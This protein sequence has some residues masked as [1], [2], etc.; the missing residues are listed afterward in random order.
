MKDVFD[1]VITRLREI[2]SVMDIKDTEIDL[3]VSPKRIEKKNLLVDG[4]KIESWRVL[5]ND[6]LGPGKGGIRFHPKVSEAEVKS[7]AFWMTLKNSLL[8]L[9]F[10]GAKG[11]IKFNP[12]TRTKRELENISRIYIREHYLN[13][14]QDKDIPAPDVYTNPQIMG[15]MLDEYEKLV[16]HH[17]PGMITGKPIEIGGCQL[18]G[19]ATA[20]GGFI[21]FNEVIQHDGLGKKP[22]IAIQGFGNAGMNIAKMLY[23]AGFKIIAVSDSKGGLLDGS[24]LDINKVIEIKSEKSSVTDGNGKI[25]TNNELLELKVDI[26][27]LAALEDQ[28]TVKN[29]DKIQAKYIIELANGPVNP[30]ADKILVSKK[31]TVVPDILANA[32]GVVVSYFEWS[33]NRTGGILEEEYLARKL[34]TMMENAWHGVYELYKDRGNI[35]LRSSAYILAISR[36]LRAEKQRGNL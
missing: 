31:I 4:E 21:I 23:N 25:I 18:R 6:A 35:D 13:L 16:G 11:G 7:L 32:G 15:W 33:Q 36:V 9:P 20:K 27:I 12:K 19:D 5:Y 34:Q 14:G 1:D 8:S 26:L 30:A 28:V 24:G 29:A 2:R 3:L 10:G 17:E 22:T